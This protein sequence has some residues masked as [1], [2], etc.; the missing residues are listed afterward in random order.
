MQGNVKIE[1]DWQCGACGVVH[2]KTLRPK[3]SK[4]KAGKESSSGSESS[5]T[6]NKSG[7]HN[8]WLSLEQKL[9]IISA[10]E[11]G[12][13]AAHIGRLH[14]INESTVRSILKNKDK[15]HAQTR[16]T[17]MANKVALKCMSPA[18]QVTEHNLVT[19]IEECSAS[20]QPLTVKMI[21]AKARELFVIAKEQQA[22]KTEAEE[23]ETFVASNGWFDSFKVRTG[24]H[25]TSKLDGTDAWHFVI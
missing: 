6:K 13:K 22:N 9:E 3:T 11:E 1:N 7:R 10:H 2:D 15:I 17:Y 19:W 24:L 23:K 18:K 16:N 12:F 4:K 8:K 5:P 25:C 14:G 21:K 20:K